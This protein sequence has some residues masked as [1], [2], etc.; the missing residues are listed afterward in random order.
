MT[1]ATDLANWVAR[2]R[3]LVPHPDRKVLLSPPRL[4]A[5]F[6]GFA[7]RRTMGEAGHATADDVRARDPALVTLVGDLFRLLGRHYFR[8]QVEGVEHVPPTGPMLLVGN[9]SGGLLPSEGFF[10]ALAIHDH[11]G[12][13][14]AIYALAHDFLFED[15]VLRRYAGRLGILRAGHV[16]A[17]HAFAAGAG[18]L[19]YPGS[20]LDTFRPFGDRD[21]IVLGG[22]TGFVELALR[23][24]V[25]IVPVVTA[26][27]H[28]QLIVLRRGDRLARRVGAHRWARTEVLPLVL[29]LP[30]GLT[31]GFLPYLP[32]PAQT[33]VAFLP[34]MRWPDLGPDAADDPAAVARCYRDVEAAMQATLDRLTRDRRYLLG[35]PPAPVPPLEVATEIA[36]S[37]EAVWHALTDLAAYPRWNPFIRQARGELVPGGRVH[38]RVRTPMG[39]PLRFTAEVLDRIEDRELRWRGHVGAPWLAAGEHTFTIEALGPERVRLIQREVFGGSLPPIVRRVLVPETRRAFAIMNRALKAHVERPRS[40]MLAAP[41]PGA[42]PPHVARIESVGARLPAQVLTTAALMASTR[43]RTR[44]DLERLT[45]IRE[46]RVC[47]PDEDTLTLAIDAA[48]DCLARSRY[49][50][51]DLDMVISTSISRHV[52]AA[53]HRF[54]PPLSLS[55]K[56]AIGASAATSFDLSNA[57]AGMLTG[58]FLLD[59][60]VRRG[61]IRRGMVV[62]G[63]HISGLGQNATRS[64]R[65]ILSPELASLTLGDAG[66]AVIVD[67]A[68]DGRAGI[69]LAGFTTLAEHSRLCVGLPAPHQPGARMFTRARRIHEVAMAD[70]PPLLAEVL[71]GHGLHLGDVD[72]LIPHQTSVRAIRAGEKVLAERTGE[73]PGHTIVTV[74]DY[75]NTASTTLFLALHRY[76]DAGRFAAGDRVLL[77]SV[78]SGLE[79]GVVSL[80]MDELR[81]THGHPH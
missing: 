13:D 34:P 74:D 73:R 61:A 65:S 4:V 44:I 76:L 14:R 54:E 69:E 27:T 19:V 38:V 62:S 12:A 10:T 23:E 70:G 47:G 42:A 72:W 37:P 53:T 28:E 63:E 48:R 17:R 33:T 35:P 68:A 22:R 60:L 8:L 52:G 30:W 25:P 18:V 81:D 78:A 64:V 75:G 59:D 49:V 71:E 9:H 2:A 40:W 31:T 55:I 57:C 16:S 66:A 11:L 15:P 67:R 58:V 56:E 80:V 5:R 26:G 32:L 77:L 20:D 1:L 39:L 45:G 3:R 29:A 79:V 50:G 24:G 36:A 7:L 43:H 6:A 21:R 46:R 51:A 41:G